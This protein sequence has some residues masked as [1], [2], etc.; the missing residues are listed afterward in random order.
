LGK[1]KRRIIAR[2]KNSNSDMC[3]TRQDA[4][5]IVYESLIDNNCTK[6]AQEIIGLFGLSAEELAE[7]GLSYEI[8]K[9]LGKTLN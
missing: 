4:I 9:A 6:K 3:L 7:A 8:L 5:N 2:A 1:S